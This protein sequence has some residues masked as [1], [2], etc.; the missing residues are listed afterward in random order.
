MSGSVSGASP[1]WNRSVFSFFSSRRVFD[2]FGSDA[3]LTAA[4]NDGE[5]AGETSK[6]L[7]GVITTLY[8][9]CFHCYHRFYFCYFFITFVILF[10]VIIIITHYY[11]CFLSLGPLEGFIDTERRSKRGKRERK[12]LWEVREKKIGKRKRLKANEMKR[13]KRE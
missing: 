12:R 2:Q 6:M 10:T 8:R 5:E 3:R 1:E 9:Y 7:M 13:N 11:H 4:D